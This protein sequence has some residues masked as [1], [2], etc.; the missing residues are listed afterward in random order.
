MKPFRAVA[1]LIGL[2]G[3]LVVGPAPQALAQMSVDEM[4]ET[5]LGGGT[6]E[7]E[8][9]KEAER[10]RREA[11][12]AA[13][14]A[15]CTKERARFEALREASDLDGMK[16]ILGGLQCEA[17]RVAV[18]RFIENAPTSAAPAS[19]PEDGDLAPGMPLPGDDT[20]PKTAD[21]GTGA[22]DTAPSKPWADLASGDGA[23]AVDRTADK[24]AS[25]V[26]PYAGVRG[27]EGHPL[28]DL[29]GTEDPTL[30]R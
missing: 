20:T 13:K 7:E 28:Y 8:E 1:F 10:R 16:G 17:V 24:A 15:R 18:R 21:A 23:A 19:A 11:E 5:L 14:K 9:R 30:A 25:G 27:L 12:A 2:A 22:G 6:P 4:N 26:S 29:L 3:L